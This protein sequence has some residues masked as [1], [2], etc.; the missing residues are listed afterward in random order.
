MSW[1][2][3]L[4]L[5]DDG[6]LQ[7]LVKA[8]IREA[9]IEFTVTISEKEGAP[10]VLNL[11][12]SGPEVFRPILLLYEKYKDRMKGYLQLPD[13]RTYEL[14]ESN[15]EIIRRASEGTIMPAAASIAKP[16]FWEVYQ[17]EIGKIISD[18]PNILK[19]YPE[20]SARQNIR[21]TVAMLAFLFG[22]L[23]I[24]AYLANLRLV[25][26]DAIVLLIGSIVG[27]VFAFLQR[28]LGVFVRE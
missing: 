1:Q 2:G 12:G 25:S 3:S 9:K 7:E 5:R 17:P 13:N 21:I 28:Y 10:F 16:S 22:V 19:W 14:N 4:V 27:Y 23:L 20:T 8:C 18:L 24:T 6:D 15:I 26:G 11:L